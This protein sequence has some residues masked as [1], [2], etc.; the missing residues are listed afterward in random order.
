MMKKHLL[1][2]PFLLLNLSVQAQNKE[3]SKK[4][5]DNL[6]VKYY[7]QIKGLTQLMRIPQARM[8]YDV[9]IK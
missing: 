9:V 5:R 2:L 3:M 4:Y 8:P 6:N 7:E 1:L